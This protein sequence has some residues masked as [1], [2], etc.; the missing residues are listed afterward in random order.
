ML[1]DLSIFQATYVNV[2]KCSDAFLT[3]RVLGDLAVASFNSA[4]DKVHAARIEPM[5]EWAQL[6]ALRFAIEMKQK[7]NIMEEVV[8]LPGRLR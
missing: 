1:N 8:T 2:I 6:E 4:P 7:Y 5:V 3:G